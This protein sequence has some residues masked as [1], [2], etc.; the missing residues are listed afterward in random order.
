MR[1]TKKKKLEKIFVISRNELV[2]F[3]NVF[4][5]PEI[6][7]FFEI[8]NNLMSALGRIKTHVFLG[9]ARPKSNAHL[10]Q[11]KKHC[12]LIHTVGFTCELQVGGE[13]TGW[14]FFEGLRR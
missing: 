8:D 1:V 12:G 7:S 13:T 6:D 10:K 3:R 11:R 4:L 5:S 14:A 9:N 2:F